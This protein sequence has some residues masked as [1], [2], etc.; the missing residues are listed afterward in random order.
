MKSK[1]VDNC[2]ANSLGNVTIANPAINCKEG[3]ILCHVTSRTGGGEISVLQ[4]F[5]LA[6]EYYPDLP[7]LAYIRAS[8]NVNAVNR[9]ERLIP[10]AGKIRVL[11]YGSRSLEQHLSI[12][13]C[14]ARSLLST[15]EELVAYEGSRSLAEMAIMGKKAEMNA[16]VEKYFPDRI[17][18]R[19]ARITIPILDRTISKQFR[20]LPDADK[21]R[22]LDA[23]GLVFEKLIAAELGG[24]K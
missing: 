23:V 12:P 1:F 15:P 13:A 6:A 8:T 9:I 17:N 4:L 18:T 16:L 10:L 24:A 2:L 21:A 7:I 22:I 3:I 20:T 19:Q 14:S 11:Y 5:A